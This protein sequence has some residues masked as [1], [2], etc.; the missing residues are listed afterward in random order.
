M[1]LK[2]LFLFNKPLYLFTTV[3]PCI[4][5]YQV[6]TLMFGI[7][8]KKLSKKVFDSVSVDV[9]G[10]IETDFVVFKLYIALIKYTLF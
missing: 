2:S 5:P 8:F 7:F 3:I 6:Q 4:I 9:I 1:N 10:C